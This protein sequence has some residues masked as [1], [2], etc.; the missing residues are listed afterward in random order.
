[1]RKRSLISL[2]VVLLLTGVA[3]SCT[4]EETRNL[5]RQ[6]KHAGELIE[7][8]AADP[9]IRQ[10]GKDVAANSTVIEK[11][12]GPP[13][14]DKPYSPQESKDARDK[15]EQAAGGG[16]LGILSKVGQGIA[17]ALTVAATALNLPIVG[18]W[19]ATTRVGQA[20]ARIVA[21]KTVA[22]GQDAIKTIS[23]LRSEAEE[24]PL[25]PQR[26]VELAMATFSKSTAGIA[27]KVSDQIEAAH[28]IEVTPIK[29][30]GAPPA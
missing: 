14:E 18:P 6:N 10:A 17:I 19:L 25:T 15:G 5:N 26:V 3:W 11:I 9:E 29:D 4:A 27:D 30:L 28:K 7:S 21:G 16:I 8:K 22:V 20:A 12:E 13:K 24:K 2:F 23:V 1:M